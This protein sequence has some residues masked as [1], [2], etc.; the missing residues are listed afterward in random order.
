MITY[1]DTSML[2]K[3]LVDDER[4]RPTAER[5]WLDA[6]FV[7][8]AEI[9]YAEA[10]SALAAARR[11]ER[12]NVTGLRA[13]KQGL[14]LLWGQLSL[15]AVD[16]AL[17]QAAGDIADRD[18]LRGYDAVHLAAAI[19]AEVSVVASS[20]QELVVAARRCGLA[21]AEP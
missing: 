20:D 1:F 3:L 21:T 11:H 8:C 19:A 9:G 13:A 14:E 15:V 10:R 2:V 5:L 16:T 17:V 4:G 7:V 12:L 6:S 18:G